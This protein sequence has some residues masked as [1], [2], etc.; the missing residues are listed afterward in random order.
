MNTRRQCQGCLKSQERQ[1]T[2]LRSF[3]QH[4]E[5]FLDQVSGGATAPSGSRRVPGLESD[6]AN[7][8]QGHAFR[9]L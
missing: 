3:A 5:Q 9:C 7:G 2:G 6:G 4:V 1:L 8:A